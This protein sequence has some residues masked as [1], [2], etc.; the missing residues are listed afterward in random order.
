MAF[1][2]A[3]N[4]SKARATAAAFGADAQHALAGGPE[5]IPEFL[6]VGAGYI[7]VRNP[8]AG[9]AVVVQRSLPRSAV[10][11][12]KVGRPNPAVSALKRAWSVADR[13]RCH[14]S[15]KRAYRCWRARLQHRLGCR[16]RHS[17]RR[18]AA[19]DHLSERPCS[20]AVNSAAVIPTFVSGIGEVEPGSSE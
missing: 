8:S 14:H 16:D 6:I 3:P 4:R 17:H 1:A 9:S 19:S 2:R 15:S 12:E 7:A 11:A 20:C 5:L 13:R 18:T 10:S